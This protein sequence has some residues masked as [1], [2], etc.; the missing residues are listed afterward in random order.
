M[1]V[2]YVSTADGVGKAVRAVME[3][4]NWRDIIPENRDILIKVNLTWDYVRPGVDT[5]PWVVEAFAELVKDHVRDIYIGES[6]QILVD[7]DRAF[8]VTGMKAAADRQGLIWHNFSKNRWLKREVNGLTFSIPEICTQMPVI[9]IPVV[10]THYRSVISVALKH[11]YGC[12]DDNRHNYHYR[13]ADYVTAVNSQIPVVL[14]LADG[15]I[16]L[17]GN[18]PKPGIPKQTDFLAASTDRVALDYSVSKV[19][20]IDPLSVEATVKADGIAGSMSNVQD[21]CLPPMES[22]PSFSFQKARPNFVARIEKLLRGGKERDEPG[23]DGPLIGILK[24]GA[25]KWYNFAYSLFGQKRQA[26]KFISENEYGT[27][28]AGKPEAAADQ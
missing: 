5:S 4:L 13:L 15:T 16:S 2:F 3:A 22:P 11:L 28:W 7:A 20:G 21:V 12:L 6:S 18:G 26:E 25:K 10:K 24:Y 9:S 27:Q 14:T 8:R 1:K 17:E 23:T 19:M